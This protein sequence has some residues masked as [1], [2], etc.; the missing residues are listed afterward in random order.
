M[1]IILWTKE[2]PKMVE[3]QSESNV[4]HEQSQFCIVFVIF[5][6]TKQWKNRP[7]LEYWQYA[8]NHYLFLYMRWNFLGKWKYIRRN[9]TRQWKNITWKYIAG[10]IKIKFKSSLEYLQEMQS[11]SFK[12]RR[13]PAPRC[14]QRCSC[15][16]SWIHIIRTKDI[17]GL[18][19][20]EGTAD[21]FPYEGESFWNRNH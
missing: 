4:N 20:Y 2:G 16:R 3:A 19:C 6:E 8:E 14:C 5:K 21:V 10:N 12:W 9:I 13:F 1:T 17:S 11:S 18:R 15:Q 7:V